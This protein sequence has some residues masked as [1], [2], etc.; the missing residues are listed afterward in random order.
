MDWTREDFEAFFADSANEAGFE[1][2]WNALSQF[3][4]DHIQ[5]AGIS[6]E[7]AMNILQSEFNSLVSQLNYQYSTFPAFPCEGISFDKLSLYNID[8][9]RCTGITGEQ[10]A[11][12]AALAMCQFNPVDFA[13]IDLTNNY[14]ALA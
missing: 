6:D 4:N 13:G 12:T 5:G 7:D 2:V 3:G 1:E 9:S 14:L 10:L 11:S 8:F